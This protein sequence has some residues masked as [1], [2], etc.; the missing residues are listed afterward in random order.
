[1]SEDGL[2]PKEL[3]RSIER[4]VE[5]AHAHAPPRDEPAIRKLLLEHLG[6]ELAE[7]PVVSAPLAGY[8]RV[9]F[10]VALDAFLAADGRASQLIGLSTMRGYRFGLAELGQP[11]SRFGMLPDPGPAEYE[12]VAVGERQISCV[13][14]GLWLIDDD[15]TPLALLLTREEHGPSEAELGLEVMARTRESAQTFLSTLQTL[16]DKHNVYRGRVLELTGS[17]WG[18]LGVAVRQLPPVERDR[19]VLRSGVLERIERHTERFSKHADELRRAGRHLRRGLLMH[20]PP[21]TGKTLTA[22]YLS[23]LMP[24][25]TTIILA[26]ESLSLIQPSCDMARRLAPAMLILE[27]VDLVAMERDFDE[28]P[29]GILFELLNQMDGMNEDV[30]IVFVLTTNRA[31]VL[32]PALVARPGRI[33]LAVE[34]PL[35]DADARSRLIDLYGEGLELDLRDR[36]LIVEQTEGAS[37]AFIRELLRRSTLV[38]AD[39]G[40]GLRVTDT[41]VAEALEEL[42]QAGSEL[43]QRLLG[44]GTESGPPERLTGLPDSVIE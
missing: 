37:P 24:D 17:P 12:T 10:Q 2:D 39:K 11:A 36:A 5:W 19:I 25:R 29:G 16:M 35:P 41:H 6:G 38:A 43:T 42:Q 23:A 8:E 9:N 30:D 1:M 18:G 27:D 3:A 20:G 7:M 28:S 4:L 34:M 14:T 33:D 44:A 32:E 15:G 21:G 22:M 26:G 40:A 31:D 13:A